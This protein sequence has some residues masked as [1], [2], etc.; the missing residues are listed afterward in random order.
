MQK[1]LFFAL[2]ATDP[3][4]KTFTP[5]LK[6][7]KI[8]ADQREVA[9]K[10]TPPENYHVTL[11]FLGTHEES[12]LPDLE[13]ILRNVCERTAPFELKIENIGAFASEQ[14]ARVLWLG[15]QNKK[16]LGQL[17][18]VLDE[19]LSAQ[20]FL[21]DIETRE[22]VPHLT[23]GRLRNPRSVKDLIS[24]LKRKSFG[25][26]K[27]TEL[28]LYESQLQGVFPVYTPV[29]RRTLSGPPEGTNAS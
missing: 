11:T 22:F 28:I 24:P 13:I 3:L 10:W 12:A 29:F 4:A 25:K 27:V 15:V 20:G 16:S 14:D 26:I 7:I 19:Q 23:V 21:D 9:V 1:R 18:A 6:K 5:F 17:K 8:G 2:N